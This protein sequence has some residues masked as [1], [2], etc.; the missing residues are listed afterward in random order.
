MS[1]RRLILM[2]MLISCVLISQ[3]DAAGAAKQDIKLSDEEKT[4]A[5]EKVV[6]SGAKIKF[7]NL[8]HNFGQ[9][10]P[11]SA[12]TCEFK[13]TNTGKKK[14]K[15]T[16]VHA[17]CG[18]TAPELKKK[19]Y[20]PGESGTIKIT[21]KVP[22][23][24]GSTTK[25]IYV[26]SNDKQMPKTTLTVKARVV[27]KVSFEPEQINLS[28]K[29]ENA[30]CPKI[31]IKAVDKQP[32]A[33]TKYNSTPNC[34][35]IDVNS[36]QKATEFIFEPKIDMEELKESPR[37]RIE[38]KLTHPECEHI[39]IPFV[40]LAKFKIDPA[41]IILF[42]VKPKEKVQ[43][44][45]W[46]L[47]NYEDDFEIES[48]SSKNGSIKVLSKE[49]V[50]SRCQLQLEITA[51]AQDGEKRFFKDTLYMNLKGGEKLKIDCRGFYDKK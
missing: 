18:C 36:A 30:G 37:G 10:S 40:A 50:D 48:T 21:F 49:K 25:H 6:V 2:V 8:S 29:E 35:I 43:R 3:T 31:K 17:P 20:D 41:T 23:R 46:V 13:F 14:L 7:E 39:S 26:H 38:F 28:F 47:N 45:I 12:N 24:Q 27:M 1:C 16:K 34:I 9:V 19:K 4:Q 11:G 44:E 5:D 32:F 15:I 33:I 51:P 22:K 42:K